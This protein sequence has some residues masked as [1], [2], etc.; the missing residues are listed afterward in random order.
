MLYCSSQ[1]FIFHFRFGWF[2]PNRTAAGSSYV[3]DH[4]RAL[5]SPITAGTFAPTT[6]QWEY[7]RQRLAKQDGG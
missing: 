7:I 1:K 6:I 4:W 2:M 5:T 3:L